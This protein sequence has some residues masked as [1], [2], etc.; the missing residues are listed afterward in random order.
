MSR[1]AP[2]HPSE[3]LLENVVSALTGATNRRQLARPSVKDQMARAADEYDELA[4]EACGRALLEHLCRAPEDL[5]ALEAL[6]I[7][8]LAHP[9]V[10]L[11]HCVS[12]RAEGERLA[13]QLSRAGEPERAASLIEMIEEH[14]RAAEL[15]E[16]DSA[17]ELGEGAT[18]RIERCLRLADEA[19]RS[20]RIEQ[21]I[22]LL[23]EVILLDCDRRDVARMIRDLRFQE[24]QQRGRARKLGRWMLFSTAGVGLI[25]L[26]V[27]RERSV[28]Q[29]QA[30]V[31]AAIPGDEVSMRVRHA[32]L[33]ELISE[34]RV[35][36]GLPQALIERDELERD[37]TDLDR[38]AES[39][40]RSI[41]DARR[42]DELLANDLLERGR[43]Y[44][45]QGRFETALADLKR[46]LEVG[47]EHWVDR[48]RAEVEVAAIEGWLARQTPEA[49]S[50]KEQR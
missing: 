28:A 31:P 43:M 13:F 41:T 49:S 33:S 46:A 36:L 34:R 20:G 50:T 45:G 18:E 8:G 35:W 2:A 16:A 44:A 3:P 10:L 27:M 17:T 1:T 19:A 14:E 47:S 32:A 4:A 25:A 30:A 23:Q 48:R 22:Q 26:V 15:A 21:A 11:R 6:L 5:R 24:L 12:L 38:Q 7:L 40:E 9:S 39:K 29:V 37:L 42:R